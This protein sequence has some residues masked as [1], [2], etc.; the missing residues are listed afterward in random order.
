MTCE[1]SS[2]LQ[3]YGW[4]SAAMGISIFFDAPRCQKLSAVF[5]LLRCGC[6]VRRLHS[7]VQLGAEVRNKFRCTTDFGPQLV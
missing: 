3:F 5:I 7:L 2:L 4:P 1:Y 6:F